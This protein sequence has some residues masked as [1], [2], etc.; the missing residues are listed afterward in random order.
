MR[1]PVPWCD[2]VVRRPDECHWP[3]EAATEG[4]E[5]AAAV[6]VKPL[7][8]LKNREEREDRETV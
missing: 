5:V 3:V 6:A 1:R 7:S 8:S 4:R 2:K